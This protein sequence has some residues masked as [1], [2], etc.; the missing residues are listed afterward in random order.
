MLV[1]VAPYPIHWVLQALD[2][3]QQRPLDVVS[4]ISRHISTGVDESVSIVMKF[5][6]LQASRSDILAIASVSLPAADHYDGNTPVLRIQG[7]KG[8]IQVF[9]P[10]W[11][12][13]KIR[14]IHREQVFGATGTL[15]ESFPNDIPETV[16]G[17]C[18]EADEAAR[19][20]REG[21]LESPRMPWAQTLVAMQILD[22][23]RKDNAIIFPGDIDSL[24]Y[25]D[26]YEHLKR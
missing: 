19:C 4:C 7:D 18:F 16:H 10:S 3:M 1:S 25:P 8:E 23:V 13:S 17:L 20:I 9:G 26:F 2:P 24:D 11:R 5:A 12:P 22:K 6:P 21:Q 15:L 14:V